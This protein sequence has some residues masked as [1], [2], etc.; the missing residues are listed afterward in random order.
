MSGSGGACNQCFRLEILDGKAAGKSLVVM[1]ANFCPDNPGPGGTCPSSPS[2][3]NKY[4]EHYHFDIAIP[5]GGL[6][7]Q[8]RCTKQYGDSNNDWKVYNE[9]DCNKLPEDVRSGCKI[10]YNDLD[11]MDNPKVSWDKIACPAG[12]F[13]C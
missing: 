11:G 8:G 5:G 9:R 3:T 2:I 13:F 10:W 6:G 1:A 4:G 12:V 7:Y